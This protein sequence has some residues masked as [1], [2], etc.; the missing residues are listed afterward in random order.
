MKSY[1]SKVGPSSNIPGALI[2]R[3]NLDTEADLNSGRRS[4]EEIHGEDRQL[5]AK[6]YLK[7][8]EARTEV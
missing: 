4:C 3:G 1:W 2:K 7:L 8:S 5:Q 6:E